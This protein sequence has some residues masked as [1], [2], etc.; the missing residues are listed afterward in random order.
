MIDFFENDMLYSVS[1]DEHDCVCSLRHG[2]EGQLLFTACQHD[3]NNY[4]GTGLLIDLANFEIAKC[5]AKSNVLNYYQINSEAFQ[6]DE[7]GDTLRLNAFGTD[8]G[9]HMLSI[10]K[11]I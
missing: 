7:T 9:L 8:G 2:D 6:A 11:L 5:D 10:R 4:G 1:L 3:V